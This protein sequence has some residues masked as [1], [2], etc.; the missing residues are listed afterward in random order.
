MSFSGMLRKLQVNVSLDQPW[1]FVK[2]VIVFPG[3]KSVAP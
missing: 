3:G 2:G 1:E